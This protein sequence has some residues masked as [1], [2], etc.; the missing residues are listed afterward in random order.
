[1]KQRKWRWSRRKGW[2]YKRRSRSSDAM[3][4]TNDDALVLNFVAQFLSDEQKRVFCREEQ[5]A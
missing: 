3:V 4:R 5:L 2:R 1:L